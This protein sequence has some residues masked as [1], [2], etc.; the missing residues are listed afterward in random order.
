MTSDIE[1]ILTKAAVAAIDGEMDDEMRVS[2]YRLALT[3]A[4]E[5]LFRAEELAGGVVNPASL[6]L[7]HQL[8][9][10]ADPDVDSGK[11]MQNLSHTLEE[12]TEDAPQEDS[13][14]VIP[15]AS[16]VREAELGP[17]SGDS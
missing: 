8:G 17:P 16:G 4:S 7:I 5:E 6:L 15:D 2:L 3:I 14:G 13:G 11:V 12:L 9:L 1:E 10:L